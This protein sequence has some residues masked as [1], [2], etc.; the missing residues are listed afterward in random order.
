MP[1]VKINSTD[2]SDL[3]KQALEEMNNHLLTFYSQEDFLK[4][5]SLSLFRLLKKQSIKHLL[6]SRKKIF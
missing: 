6:M 5:V 2:I 3:M 4:S 1:N